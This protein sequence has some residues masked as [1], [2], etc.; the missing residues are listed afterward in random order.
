MYF[1]RIAQLHSIREEIVE[2]ISA[3]FLAILFACG[4]MAILVPAIV[5]IIVATDLLG[6][7]STRPVRQTG[8]PVEL[9]RICDTAE[10]N[11]WPVVLTG[12]LLIFTDLSIVR[13]VFT[14]PSMVMWAGAVMICVGV[15]ASLSAR[16]STHR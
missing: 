7:L 12:L 1:G 5:L 8:L 3:S 9:R 11:R 10:R 2:F 13:H 16:I 14:T 15:C 6:R 4:A